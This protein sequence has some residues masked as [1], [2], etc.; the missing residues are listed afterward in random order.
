MDKSRAS[1]KESDIEAILV[2]EVKALGGR[3]YK[4]VSPGNSGVPDRIV[5]LPYGR[6]IFVELKTDQ[7]RLTKL[8]RVQIDRLQDLGADTCVVRGIRGLCEFFA[9]VGAYD[10][11]GRLANRYT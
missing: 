6:V 4:F 1:M 9:M 3:A 11:A 2:K 5:V 8:Q 7:G 10:T